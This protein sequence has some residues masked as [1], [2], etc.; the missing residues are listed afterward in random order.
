[1]GYNFLAANEPKRNRNTKLVE[2]K[3]KTRKTES[4]QCSLGTSDSPKEPRK[5]YLAFTPI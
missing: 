3:I 1:M 4:Q 5:A 2:R